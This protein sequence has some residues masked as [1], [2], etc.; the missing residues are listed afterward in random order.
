MQQKFSPDAVK[1]I[2]L[3]GHFTTFKSHTEQSI[4]LSGCERYSNARRLRNHNN[5]Q[6]NIFTYSVFNVLIDFTE[7]HCVKRLK[8]KILNNGMKT[9]NQ[10]YYGGS[11]GYHFNEIFFVISASSGV[12]SLRK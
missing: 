2:F 5:P 7:L 8:K 4:Y 6:K 3:T 9:P 1:H 10:G 12:Y 11:G